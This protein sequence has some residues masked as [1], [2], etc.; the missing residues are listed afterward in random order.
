MKISQFF[1]K[2]LVDMFSM[3]KNHLDNSDIE[4]VK[5]YLFGD[6]EKVASESADFHSK[7]KLLGD[8]SFRLFAIL[9]G[10]L[11]AL[12]ADHLATPFYENRYFLTPFSLVV[13]AASF[14]GV[15]SILGMWVTY[16]KDKDFQRKFN[17]MYFE[18][19]EIYADYKVNS[20]KEEVLKLITS[21]RD[22]D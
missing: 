1:F 5:K 6:K 12:Y 7:M 11:F 16:I 20:N 9:I 18:M 2:E 15:L 4:V 19:W 8:T 10:V 21:K 17:K 13:I 22:Q 14:T 3:D